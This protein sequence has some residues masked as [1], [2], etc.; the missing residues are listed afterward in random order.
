MEK[1]NVT[2]HVI[3]E[4]I[5]NRALNYFKERINGKRLDAILII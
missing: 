2:V 4:R 3:R 5:E 1:E